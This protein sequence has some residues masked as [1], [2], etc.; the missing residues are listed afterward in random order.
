MFHYTKSRVR[1]TFKVQESEQFSTV[2]LHEVNVHTVNSEKVEKY[3]LCKY[4][5]CKHI[6]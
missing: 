2:F 6:S 1:K 5:Q 3:I 4:E